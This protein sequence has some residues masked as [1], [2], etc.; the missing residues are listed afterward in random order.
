M[1][2]V[3]LIDGSTSLEG[4]VEVCLNNQWQAICAR[5]TSSWTVEDA[6]VVCR[7]LGHS[8]IGMYVSEASWAVAR[9][10]GG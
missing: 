3:R 2:A 5:Y 7:Q 4:R 1:G 9:Q 6:R 8:V 10:F